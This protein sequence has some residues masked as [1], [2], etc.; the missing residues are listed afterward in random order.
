MRKKLLTSVRLLALLVLSVLTALFAACDEE[1]DVVFSLDE[2]S[3]ELTVGES[4]KVLTLSAANA[5]GEIEWASTDPEVA[6]VTVGASAN[7]AT[8]IGVSKGNAVITVKAGNEIA[9]CAV[10]VNAAPRLELLTKGLNLLVGENGKVNVDSDIA[11]LIYS[12]GNASV[13][14]VSAEGI[15]SAVGAGSTVI[16]VS[17]AN[18]YVYCPVDVTAPEVSIINP[19][20]KDYVIQLTLEG[21]TNTYRLEAESNGEI[22]WFTGNASIATVDADGL[23]TAVAMGETTVTA[24]YASAE[25]TRVVKIKDEIIT[26]TLSE[27]EYT[28]EEKQSFTLSATVS[29]EQTGDDAS[30]LWSVSCGE[31]IVTVD[32]NGT[33][34]AT[35]N[36]YGTA[37]IRATSKKDTDI[38]AECAVTVPDPTGDWIKV[39]DRASLEAALNAANENKNIM[40]TADIDLGGAKIK[41]GLNSYRGIFDGKGFTISNY[42]GMLFH[43]LSG[44]LQNL[45]VVCTTE[46]LANSDGA[47]M[48]HVNGDGVIKN[49][50]IDV[51]YAQDVT[52]GIACFVSGRV[53]NTII[54]ARNTN[55]VG[56]AYV[57]TVQPNA[58]TLSNVYYVAYGSV[59]AN[60]A[61]Q[62]TEG[63]LKQPET[64]DESWD[65]G[66]VINDGE[67]P[68]I[69]NANVTEQLKVKVEKK[70]DTLYVGE[71]A[72]ITAT[73]TPATLTDEEREVEWS[74]SD[75]SVA[76]V[77]NGVVTA[78]KA[79]TVT[80]RV[81]SKNEESKYAECVITVN[82]ITLSINAADKISEIKINNQKNLGYTVNRG[83]VEWSTSDE[84]VATVE[85]GLVKAVGAGEVTI[86]VTSKL[87]PTVKDFVT[88]TVKTKVEITVTLDR[89]SLNLDRGEQASLNATITNSEMGVKWT[90]SDTSVATV[91]PD[92]GK[93]T[94]QGKDG[95]ATITATSVE[96]D[97]E[98]NYAYAICEVKVEYVEAE[99]TYKQDSLT[100]AVGGSVALN[101]IATAT[102]GELTLALKSG[103]TGGIVTIENGVITAVS[104][105]EVTAVLVWSIG[106]G[107][108]EDVVQEISVKVFMPAIEMSID[109]DKLTLKSGE[110]SEARI[111]HVTLDYMP[112]SPAAADVVW[113]SGDNTIA[114][115]TAGYQNG[116]Y[117]GTINAHGEGYTVIT[118]TYMLEGN[119]Y[120]V[121][122]SLAVFT[123]N[124][125]WTAVYNAAGF[126]NI[127]A[128]NYYVVKDID[129]GGETVTGWNQNAKINGMGH[130]VSN[131]TTPKLVGGEA[132]GGEIRNVKLSC[133]IGG[134]SGG[135]GLFG[136]YTTET[137]VIENCLFDVDFT[138]APVKSVLAH[139][140]LNGCK[141]KNVIIIISNTVGD[142]GNAPGFYITDGGL[143][144]TVSAGNIQNAY[145]TVKTG[146][147][148]GAAY[149]VT[150]KTEAQLKDESTYGESWFDNWLIVDG[151]LPELILTGFPRAHRHTFGKEWTYD[152]TNH[153]R[154]A[155][156]EHET[157]KADIGAH[158]ANG[159][160][161]DCTVCG[162]LPEGAHRHTYEEEWLSDGTDHWK[163]MTCEEHAG[164]KGLEAPHNTDGA[165]QYCTVC[166]G[167]A[168]LS[169]ELEYRAEADMASNGWVYWSGGSTCSG[170][171]E[172]GDITFTFSGNSGEWW[173]TQLFYKDTAI[174]NPA[175]KKVIMT[176][177]SSAAGHI[178]VNGQ[179][180]TLKAGEAQTITVN[181]IANSNGFISVQMGVAAGNAIDI[182]A[183]TITFTDITVS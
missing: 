95:T 3:I 128:G 55:G 164:E 27:T 173:C 100:I 125:N 6:T 177:T 167:R 135:H 4:G 140:A 155:T 11:S 107:D 78:L 20:N 52:G 45:N 134:G 59:I 62:K 111:L 112:A 110:S 56:Q 153:W 12:S 10:R 122:C 108:I 137:A 118:A 44:T 15:V 139:H 124:G 65:E 75:N 86:T 94:A 145:Y 32:A 138:A 146:F 158:D 92:T 149:G 50:L 163:I 61:T 169:Y 8:V 24:K 175:S 13:A 180:I 82:A 41:S 38:Y 39:S 26:V 85:N 80:V 141:V 21:E 166:G 89:T 105:G 1:P 99:I 120:E 133:G 131:F 115:V 74:S 73:V 68:V 181:G 126:K 53:E 63:A 142:G 34:Y 97:G 160:D 178:T 76:T 79:G 182:A 88:V 144:G 96:D 30:V 114:E 48:H 161:G 113:T 93:V 57:T 64:F 47:L 129:M 101:S 123:A 152:G 106:Y 25:D 43:N 5:D 116:A 176:V 151:E 7:K 87:D 19:A 119:E 81:T 183:A 28:L 66:W 58:G 49:C 132:F 159:P 46:G 72:V 17:G 2:T 98:G 71:T 148:A 18:K 33:V 162:Y 31:G 136:L 91:D 179:V 104:E 69:K 77:E 171:Y 60:N 90:S 103:S 84:S 150:N 22:E 23:L 54:F 36:A 165:L 37:Y 147:R 170:N 40:L 42:S 127:G 156:C 67:M 14:T 154:V 130:T 102:K 117:T 29:P 51:T 168:D 121:T 9:V 35:G 172:N 157:E 109:A 83:E 70:T 16:T 143:R 174:L